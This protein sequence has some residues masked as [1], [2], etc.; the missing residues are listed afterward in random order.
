MSF[1]L[2]GENP[3]S[4]R[5]TYHLKDDVKLVE[6][7]TVISTKYGNVHVVREGN[8]GQRCL[9]TIHDVALNRLYFSPNSLNNN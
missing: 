1:E 7:R 9:L 8:P 6:E 5:Q 3:T 2:V 4:E